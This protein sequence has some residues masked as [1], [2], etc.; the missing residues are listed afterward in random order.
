MTN[1]E[2]KAALAP[3]VE[4]YDMWADRAIS[5][6]EALDG[7]GVEPTSDT[8]LDDMIAIKEDHPAVAAFLDTLPGMSGGNRAKAEEQLGYCTM[9]IRAAYARCRE[10]SIPISIFD[11]LEG[12]G[13][14]PKSE[15]LLEDMASIEGDFP[16]VREWLHRRR[17]GLQPS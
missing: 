14:D 12:T 15:T 6:V 5:L 17:L 13:L 7:T 9:Q 10:M 4:Q 2:L 1:E 16:K 3:A 8:L 11:A